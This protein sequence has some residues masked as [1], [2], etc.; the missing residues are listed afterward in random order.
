MISTV[1]ESHSAISINKN[2]FK[3][4][5]SWVTKS[6]Q[7]D[8]EARSRRNIVIGQLQIGHLGEIKNNRLNKRSKECIENNIRTYQ[9]GSQSEFNFLKTIE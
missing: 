1:L 3:K 6:L 4:L 5:S 2:Q 8:Y 7:V 9:L